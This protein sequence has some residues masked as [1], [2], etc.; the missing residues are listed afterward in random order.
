MLIRLNKGTSQVMAMLLTTAT[1]FN[2][3]EL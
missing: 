2:P 1:G 3:Y